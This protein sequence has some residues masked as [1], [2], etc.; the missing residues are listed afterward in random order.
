MDFD[1]QLRHETP[2]DDVSALFQSGYYADA[3]AHL[4]R[5]VNAT[6][7][8]LVMRQALAQTAL[9][10]RDFTLA[11]THYR[12]LA[13]DRGLEDDHV[14]YL[15]ALLLSGKRKQFN[16]AM[17]ETPAAWSRIVQTLSE[18]GEI[19]AADRIARQARGRWPDDPGLTIDTGVIAGA[20]GRGDDALALFKRAADGTADPAALYNV[21]RTSLSLGDRDAAASAALQL[22]DLD[23]AHVNAYRLLSGLRDPSVWTDERVDT[24]RALADGPAHDDGARA[25]LLYALGAAHD[26]RDDIAAA[27]A[28]YRDAGVA[29]RR[30]A[31]YDLAADVSGMTRFRQAFRAPL[32]DPKKVS[33][34]DRPLV[35]VVGLPRSG[36]TLVEQIIAAHSEAD[37]AGETG[38]VRDAL[39][40]VLAGQFG[41]R[42]PFAAEF[43]RGLLRPSPRSIAR[44]GRDLR[45]NYEKLGIKSR[46]IVE[47]APRNLNYAHAL[48]ALDSAARFVVVRR[49]PRDVCVSCLTM[50]FGG[51]Y[52]FC[53]DL[54]DFVAF[55]QASAQHL[56]DL[57]EAYADRVLTVDYET[58]ADQPA[59]EIPRLIEFAG[60]E[61]EEAC[62]NPHTATKAIKTASA[63]QVRAPINKSSIGRW[64]RYAPYI[65]AY[66]DRL[67][68]AR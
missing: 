67:A 54:D 65:G 43:A 11:A 52:G 23:P 13:L 63:A 39:L 9:I 32:F 18:I 21:A 15:T 28:Y 46:C 25:H 51:T 61:M 7:H 47:K 27:V 49:D 42:T 38:V 29:A 16:S 6:S 55:A 41:S 64:Q 30:A 2:W 4:K 50:D 26:L 19:A 3:I 34:G 12:P 57:A 20:M 24:L 8:D 22:I 53:D 5:L 33:G 66:L 44:F 60:L 40:D 58:L 62:L 36:T 45:R 17:P 10:H 31:P 56:D 48:A 35:I 68:P 37:T 59:R 1:D 14:G